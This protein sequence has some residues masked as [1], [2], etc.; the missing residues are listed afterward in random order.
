MW[1]GA[2]Q[3]LGIHEHDA[4]NHHHTTHNYYEGEHPW[5]RF[6]L[7][8]RL[9]SSKRRL[10]SIFYGGH[11]VE[12]ITVQVLLLTVLGVVYLKCSNKKGICAV[13]LIELIVVT[14]EHDDVVF[15]FF[16]CTLF[17]FK[18]SK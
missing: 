10:R 14:F 13:A 8:H 6:L 4:H 15:S 17:C 18:F 2:Y 9:A 16:F 3:I 5:Q 1:A 7:L 12:S 11:P